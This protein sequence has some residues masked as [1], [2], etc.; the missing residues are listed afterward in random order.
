M[1]TACIWK[2]QPWRQVLAHEVPLWRQ[3]S[4]W[5]L[6]FIR[7]GLKDAGAGRK[8]AGVLGG[9]DR[10]AVRKAEMAKSAHETVNTLEAV[11]RDW[12]KHQ[13]AR[14]DKETHGRILA[15]LEADIFKPLGSRPLA[16][17]KPGEVMAAVKKV[18]ARGAGDQAGRLQQCLPL[19]CG[20]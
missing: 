4:A 3:K 13:A 19:G 7:V 6:V 12:L 20:A 8:S 11:A 2:S 17:I 18:E 14:W 16:S 9:C 5:P 1:A 10:G 15:S